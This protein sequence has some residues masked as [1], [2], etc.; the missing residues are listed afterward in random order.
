MLPMFLTRPFISRKASAARAFDVSSV[1][2]F[3]SASMCMVSLPSI[4][5]RC[6]S[7]VE[8]CG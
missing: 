6:S 3:T 8:R 4:L 2:R 7:S 5:R 1:E